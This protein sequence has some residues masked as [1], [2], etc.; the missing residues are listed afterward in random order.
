MPYITV[1]YPA[2]EIPIYTQCMN[3]YQARNEL[4]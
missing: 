3:I 2:K 1:H 4:K